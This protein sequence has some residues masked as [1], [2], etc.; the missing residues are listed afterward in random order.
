MTGPGYRTNHRQ[1][2]GQHPHTASSFVPYLDS[3]PEGRQESTVGK[4]SEPV[5]SPHRHGGSTQPSLPNTQKGQ[6]SHFLREAHYNQ[7][8]ESPVQGLF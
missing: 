8:S 7:V 4:D 3:A 2:W 1:K 5:L 6:S